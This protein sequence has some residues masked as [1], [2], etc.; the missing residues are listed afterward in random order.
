MFSDVAQIQLICSKISFNSGIR[1][2]QGA[3]VTVEVSVRSLPVSVK[4]LKCILT[5]ELQFDSSAN[6]FQVFDCFCVFG[7]CEH[8]AAN[9]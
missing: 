9:F 6:L 2:L 8:A 1:A 5:F 7:F 4:V 3:L